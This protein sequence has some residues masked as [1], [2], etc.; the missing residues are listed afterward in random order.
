VIGKNELIFIRDKIM[1][2]H[3]NDTN[4]IKYVEFKDSLLE[5]QQD[6]LPDKNDTGF[7]EN[8]AE[9][10]KNKIVLTARLLWQA[11]VCHSVVFYRNVDWHQMDR[12]DKSFIIDMLGVDKYDGGFV[13]L[14]GVIKRTALSF[15]IDKLLNEDGKSDRPGH[16]ESPQ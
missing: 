8:I 14:P 6:F 16:V 11:Y 13:V 2:K 10:Q 4:I 12:Y 7:E 15:Y 3:L 1:A 9:M 5:M